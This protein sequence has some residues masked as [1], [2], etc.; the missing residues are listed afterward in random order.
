MKVVQLDEWT[1]KQFLNPTSTPKIAHWGPKMS[2]MTQK[3]SQ[4]HLSELKIAQ[5]MK[6]VQLHEDISKQLWNHTPSPKIAHEGP[7]K[8]KMTQKLSQNQ[9]SELKETQKMKVVQLHEQQ[10]YTTTKL[11]SAQPN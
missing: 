7:Q 9:I 11:F 4:N 8:S 3:L 1:P 10:E 6:V 2:K 5:K